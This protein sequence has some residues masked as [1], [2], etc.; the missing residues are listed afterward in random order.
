MKTIAL[1][2]SAALFGCEAPQQEAEPVELGIVRLANSD[3][4]QDVTGSQF[5]DLIHAAPG[6]IRVAFWMGIRTPEAGTGYQV[7]LECEDP[8]G[9]STQVFSDIGDG[10]TTGSVQ[11]YWS[12]MHGEQGVAPCTL[13][14]DIFGSGSPSYDFAFDEKAL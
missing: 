10:S 7:R 12:T 13:N 14:F 9:F 11:G 4:Q 6:L 5:G 2:M 1:V 8:L 3:Y